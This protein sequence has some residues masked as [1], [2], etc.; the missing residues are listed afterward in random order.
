M[1]LVGGD[2][3]CIV[4]VWSC[5]CG[6][7]RMLYYCTNCASLERAKS[8]YCT[9]GSSGLFTMHLISASFRGEGGREGFGPP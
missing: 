1:T 8:I 5:M 2:I 9:T 4:D 6:M 3:L 7:H